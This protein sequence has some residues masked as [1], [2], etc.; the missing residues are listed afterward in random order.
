M[1]NHRYKLLRDFRATPAENFYDLQ[2]DPYEHNNLLEGDLTEEQ[3]E[4]YLALK[5]QIETLRNLSLIHISEP[6]RPY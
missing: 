1:R 2:A 3:S 5:Q 6:T 4:N